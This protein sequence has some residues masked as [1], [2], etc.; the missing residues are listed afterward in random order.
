LFE[1]PKLGPAPAVRAAKTGEAMTGGTGNRL[2]A[3]AGICLRVLKI[4]APIS[5]N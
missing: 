5:C 3:G 2:K 1:T 4:I